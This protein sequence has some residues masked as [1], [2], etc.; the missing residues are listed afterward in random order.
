MK[1]VKRVRG[2]RPSPVGAKNKGGS[3]EDTGSGRSPQL[4]KCTKRLR[5][6]W[7]DCR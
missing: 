1:R 4:A 7:L 2:L 3:E 5:N 6:W